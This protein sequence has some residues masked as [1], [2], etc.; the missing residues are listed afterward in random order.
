[1]TASNFNTQPFLCLLFRAFYFHVFLLFVR[2]FWQ[3][4]LAKGRDLDEAALNLESA[5]ELRINLKHNLNQY[6]D[7]LETIR[8]RIEGA[9]RLHHL[10]GLDF[11]E[12]DVQLEMNKLA[13]KI[14]A[15]G[16]IERY[17]NASKTYSNNKMEKTSTP[18]K[19]VDHCSCWPSDAR[20]HSNKNDPTNLVKNV[21]MLADEDEDHSKMA[22]SGLGGCDRCEM[23]DKL[24]R[25]C[26]CQSF[27]EPTTKSHNSDEME[28]DC[29]DNNM[30]SVIDYQ[31][32]PLKPNAHLYS[33]A[34]N[35]ALPDLENS[36]GL[37]PK[38]QKY[39]RHF[40]F[41]FLN[42]YFV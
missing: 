27:D 39:E 37:A 24:V 33:Y 12:K 20:F 17:R 1:M 7:R 22:D 30:K 29:F 8:E 5:R 25:T 41:D 40:S 36:C 23:N 11:K 9:V 6:S 18:S 19:D 4:Y 15:V 28:E 26:S 2:F 14:G 13:E 35:I 31:M 21:E 42:T 10:L 34:S 38:T 16:L 3:K 32:S